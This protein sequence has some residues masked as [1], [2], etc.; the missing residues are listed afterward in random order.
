MRRPILPY[1]HGYQRRRAIE[2]LEARAP[3]GPDSM[4]TRVRPKSLHNQL[5]SVRNYY[6]NTGKIVLVT[7]L[8]QIKWLFYNV[9]GVK[10][11]HESG[12]DFI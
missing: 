4:A 1:S 6:S 2:A 5:S 11:S 3:Q 9:F 10:L 12:A 8:I 7:L